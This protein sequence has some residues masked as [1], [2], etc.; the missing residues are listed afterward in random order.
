LK[1]A[2]HAITI[3]Q[4]SAMMADR[5]SP[6]GTAPVVLLFTSIINELRNVLGNFMQVLHLDAVETGY[7]T[8]TVE[9]SRVQS[10]EAARKVHADF[11]GG[12]VRSAFLDAE[13]ADVKKTL[14]AACILSLGMFNYAEKE[15]AAGE[16]LQSGRGLGSHSGRSSGNSG[17]APPSSAASMTSLLALKSLVRKHVHEPLAKRLE[18]AVFEQ[19]GGEAAAA[20][21]TGSSLWARLDCNQWLGSRRWEAS[22]PHPTV[23]AAAKL[24]SAAAAAGA[25]QSSS[26]GAAETAGPHRHEAADIASYRSAMPQLSAATRAKLLASSSSAGRAGA[27]QP[28]QP[29][30]PS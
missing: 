2:L 4:R 29:P 11:L 26:A 21:G 23:V 22:V 8:L 17:G 30:P 15:F 20:S 13:G 1:F 12:V 27:A 9:L 5:R 3:A 7:D 25:A 16:L 24:N 10:V 28:P 19:G 18:M 14:E 6:T